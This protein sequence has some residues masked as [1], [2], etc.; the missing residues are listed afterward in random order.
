MMYPLRRI[1][2]STPGLRGR[3]LG[4]TIKPNGRAGLERNNIIATGDLSQVVTAVLRRI[5]Q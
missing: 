5:F 2:A 3:G 4:T 1:N